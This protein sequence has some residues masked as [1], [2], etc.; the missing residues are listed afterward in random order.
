[1]KS[2]KSYISEEVL[3]TV[4]VENGNFDVE[5]EAVRSQINGTL[6]AVTAQ[7][8]VTPY[9]LLRKVSKALSYFH[10]ILPKRTF[11]E[12][13]KGVEVY[14]VMQFGDRMG[15]TDQGEFVHSVPAKFYLF[16]QYG[17]SHPFN[18]TYTRP[19]IDGMYRGMAKIVDQAELD[20]L[21]NAAEAMMAESCDD[22]A[23]MSQRK[24]GRE[25]IQ[26]NGNHGTP[27]TKK[28]MDTSG[29]KS[30][31]IDKEWPAVVKEAMSRKQKDMAVRRFMSHD[32]EAGERIL[33]MGKKERAEKKSFASAEKEANKWQKHRLKED[34]LDE[35][36]KGAAI[37][38]YGA[39]QDPDDDGYRHKTGERLK[40]HIERKFGKKAGEHAERH[41]HAAHFGRSPTMM[42]AD[43]K[44]PKKSPSSSM[45]TTKSGKLNKQDTKSLGS[46][47][48]RRLGSH[49]K[50]G[51]LPE[52]TLDEVNVKQIK[53][54]IDS[55]MSHDAVIGKHA[56]KRTT[57]TDD[58][59]KVIK[60]H[61]WDKRMKKEE[62]QIDEL[63]KS[64]LGSYIKKASHDVATRSAET[65]GG[66]MKS[67]AALEKQ[68]YTGFRKHGQHS[69]KMFA[70]SWKRRQGIARAADKLAK[71]ETQID[72]GGMP[73]SVIAHKQKLASMSDKEFAEK[74][75]HKTEKQLR[76]M[77]AR[78][79]YGFDK[80]TKTGSD[81]YVKRV[82]SAKQVDE[83]MGSIKK[84]Y[85]MRKM[86]KK[87]NTQVKQGLGIGKEKTST[88]LVTN[89]GDPHAAGG[90]GVHRIPRDKYDPTKHN[91]ASE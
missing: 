68:D 39:T 75:G 38:A 86:K 57:N 19:N 76:D 54:D 56:N 46:D 34:N 10:I 55:G 26:T 8:A 1:M 9:V 11:L 62:T 80:A 35:V 32:P 60:Q 13:T 24:A 15:M 23:T 81:H 65:R 25:E 12:G 29:E 51:H 91:L 22:K 49:T 90:G 14:E 4:N 83:A 72:E 69:E 85:A 84:T 44:L 43:D 61:A 37:R 87:V 58:I 66:A 31:K 28:A 71:E 45:R 63:K 59:R 89:K 5:N 40:G 74:H 79:G 30:A 17:I 82:S 36:S 2:F 53:K 48:K 47:I 6:A 70:K 7:P 16:F 33:K 18:V 20:R 52:E 88:V 27:S 78:H 73:A 77:G 41:A 21:L 3:P 50:P 67:A 42:K 64:T